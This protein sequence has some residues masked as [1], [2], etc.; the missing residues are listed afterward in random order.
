MNIITETDRYLFGHGSHYEIYEKMG[1]HIMEID[2]VWGTYFAVWA[3]NARAVSVVGNFNDWNGY[4][5]I[6]DRLGSSGIWEKFIPGIFEGEIY[7]YAI[8]GPD[9]ATHL[10]ADPYGNSSEMRPGNASKVVNIEGY[11]WNDS[12]WIDEKNK[13]ADKLNDTAM[14][15]YEVHLGSWRKDYSYSVDGF[16]GYRQL[17]HEIGAYVKDMGYTYVELMGIS[18]HP[19][20]ASW[21]Y[22]VTGY[23]APTSRHGDPK[24]FMYFVDYMHQL[25]IG[26]IL[27]WVPAHFPKDEHGLAMFDGTPTYEYADWR[28]GEQKDWGTKVFDYGKTEVVNFLIAN[29]LY[30]VEK[31]HVDALRVDAVA[32]MLYLDYA[33]RD[34]EWVPNK[35]GGNGNLEAMEFF[36]HLNSIMKKRDPRAF[37]IAEESTAWPDLTKTPEDGGLGFTFKWNMGW[38]H[39]FLD[40]VKLDPYFKKFNH[41]KM[42][43]NMTYAFS[44]K[45]VLVLSHDEVVHMKCSMLYKMPGDLETKA[46]NLKTAYT[47][48]M[49]QP[50][51]KLLFMGQEFGQR[52]EWSEARGLD[53]YLLDDPM[54]RDIKDYYKKLLHLY[55]ENPVMYAYESQEYECF[56]WINCDDGDNSVF[57]F[58][59]KAPGTF[60]YSLA[61]VCNFTPVEREAY[62]IGVPHPGK[63]KVIMSSE[64]V[65]G[66]EV[67]EYTA[68][69][70]PKGEQMNYFD[71]KLTVKLRGFESIIME[72]PKQPVKKPVRKVKKKADAT[73]KKTGTTKKSS[74]KKTK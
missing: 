6:M 2:G 17:A 16:C 15:I 51:K 48:M 36:R 30:W 43:F 49:G 44:E 71:Y 68:E 73:S 42:T 67:V 7:K 41:N 74:A 50:G 26:V 70:M 4:L 12:S 61:F 72:V 59:R 37:L 21:G 63:Y 35:Y 62:E 40:Y 55:K 29:A 28:K 39:D 56:R 34:G 32:S 13:N 10:K 65:E 1:A 18:E 54:H 52:E 53:W 11:E 69:A 66:N 22:Q 47:F 45:F 23:Y 33:R 3:P 64:D 8:T 38:M 24:D 5:G 58:I 46:S 60:N 25:G 31:Y 19:L 27:D 57:S 9:G 20:D 14:S